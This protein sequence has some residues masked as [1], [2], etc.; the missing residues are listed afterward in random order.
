MDIS[1][2]LGVSWRTS[3]GGLALI[4]T[5]VAEAITVL[6]DN[7]P[8]TVLNWERLIGGLVAGW[9]LFKARD[10]MVSSEEAGAK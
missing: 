7:N 10:N 1:K 8:A 6:T 2:V 9:A 4:L 3:L 5:T